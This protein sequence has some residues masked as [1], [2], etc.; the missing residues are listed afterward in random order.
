MFESALTKKLAAALGAKRGTSDYVSR[1]PLPLPPSTPGTTSDCQLTS[2]TTASPSRPLPSSAR[3][4]AALRS[5]PAILGPGGS[6]LL[7]HNHAHA[8]LEVRLARTSGSPVVFLFNSGLNSNAKADFFAFVPQY[9]EAIHVSVHDG[10]RATRVSLRMRCPFAHNES[11]SSMDG[12]FSPLLLCVMLD[13]MNGVFSAG[14]PGGRG[15]VA[16]L[17][18]EV[19]GR[20]LA[21]LYTFGKASAASDASGDAYQAHYQ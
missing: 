14:E 4:L 17:G 5:A 10:A 21:R 8:A 3:V 1:L 7:V 18:L 15:M 11:V 20:V 13:A 12:T 16:L 2:R 6:R 19:E 9:D